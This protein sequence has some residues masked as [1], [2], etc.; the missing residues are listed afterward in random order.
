MALGCGVRALYHRVRG[1]SDAARE[2]AAWARGYLDRSTG[3]ANRREA[4]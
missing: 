4:A 2:Q 1:D 3:R